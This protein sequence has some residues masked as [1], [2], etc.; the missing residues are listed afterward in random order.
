MITLEL[1]NSMPLILKAALQKDALYLDACPFIDFN[2]LELNSKLYL[3]IVNEQDEA[4]GVVIAKIFSPSCFEIHGGLYKKYIGM[5]TKVFKEIVQII[6][7]SY[8][9]EII[10]F[11]LKNNIAAQKMLQKSGFIEKA[12]IHNGD[13]RGDLLLFAER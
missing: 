11:T 8:G 6:K 13:P 3:H 2:S 1:L 7:D 12:V 10:T 4:I 5:G 9:V